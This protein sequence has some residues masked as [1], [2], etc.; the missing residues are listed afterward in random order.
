MPER[1]K[2]AIIILAAGSSKRLGY[3]KQLIK[4]DGETLILK[5]VKEAIHSKGK[6]VVVVLGSTYKL[7]QSEIENLN[8]EIVINQEWQFGIGSSIHAGIKFLKKKFPEVDGCLLMVCDQVFLRTVILDKLI[9]FFSS[10]NHGIVASKYADTFGVPVVFDK[11]YFDQLLKTPL[12]EGAK[13]IVMRYKELVKSIPFQE[14]IYDLDL[15]EDHKKLKEW[16]K[17]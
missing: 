11:E 5:M 7:I 8:I 15:P 17:R 3:P 9:Q 1:S 2:V 4:I 13:K 16:L 10:S 14:G 6:P 12:N